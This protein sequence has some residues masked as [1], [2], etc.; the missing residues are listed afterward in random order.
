MVKIQARRELDHLALLDHLDHQA[1]KAHNEIFYLK[2]KI[3]ISSITKNKFSTNRD[4]VT[5]FPY[6]PLKKMK[7]KAKMCAKS[8]LLC[9]R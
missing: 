5:P 7:T 1:P 6:P 9:I 3:K 4:T 8:T 2:N